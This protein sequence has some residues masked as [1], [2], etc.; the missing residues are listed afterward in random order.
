[1]KPFWD[2][3]YGAS[4]FAYG[5]APNQFLKDNISALPKGKIL[6]AAE[7]EGRNAVYA[8]QQ[9]FEVYAFD[10]S[11]AG[12]EKALNLAAATQ[13]LIDYT[14]SDV[15]EVSYPE[16]LFDGLVLIFAHFPATIRKAAHLKLLSLLKP[17]G[18][19]IFEAFAKNQLQYNSGGPKDVDMLFSLDEISEEFPNVKFDS[20]T[21][22]IIT[23]DEGL[24]HRGEG[25]LIRFI[26][27]K[28]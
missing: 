11:E 20:L 6:F 13:V 7:G 4:D 3:R 9:G 5:T 14:V 24:Y 1:M 26:G 25:A 16:E 2:E 28:K 17:G 21:N 23:L 18:V 10:Y 22:E 8:A 19:I 12:K 27:T 15:L